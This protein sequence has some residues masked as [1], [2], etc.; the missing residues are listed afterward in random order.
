MVGDL[1]G[2]LWDV[3]AFLWRN[4]F[5]ILEIL[6]TVAFLGVVA[7]IVYLTVIAGVGL[8]EVIAGIRDRI[9]SPSS[10]ANSTVAAPARPRTAAP[11]ARTPMA[12]CAREQN[13]IIF[14]TRA[15]AEARVEESKRRVG[16]SR[17][18]D[19]AL[20]HAYECPHAY[21]WHV[22]STESY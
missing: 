4:F 1:F 15:Q 6:F 14:A 12:R 13:K 19:K 5:D 16:E 18:Y 8:A 22:S 10:T 11:A 21:R 3:I 9:R 7:G 2:F 20:D 17:R